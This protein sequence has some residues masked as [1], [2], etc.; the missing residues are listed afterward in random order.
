[1]SEPKLFISSMVKR[2]I[3]TSTHYHGQRNSIGTIPSSIGNNIRYHRPSK[4]SKKRFRL[5]KRKPSISKYKK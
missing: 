3:R 5:S 2:V 1:M 4:S